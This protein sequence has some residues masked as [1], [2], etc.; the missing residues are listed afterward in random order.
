MIRRGVFLRVELK[1]LLLLFGVLCMGGSSDGAVLLTRVRKGFA[2]VEA[3]LREGDRVERISV[4]E[5]EIPATAFEWW[6]TIEE[7]A[8]REDV[9]LHV[10]RDGTTL[11]IKLNRDDW[12]VS[13]RPLMDSDANA[14]MKDLASSILSRTVDP[15]VVEGVF[16]RLMTSGDFGTAIWLIFETRVSLAGDEGGREVLDRILTTLERRV[17]ESPDPRIGLGVEYVRAVVYDETGRFDEA[18]LALKKF[19]E[20]SASRPGVQLLP[21]RALAVRAMALVNSG[22]KEDGLRHFGMAREAVEKIAPDSM[23]LAN[24]LHEEGNLALTLGKL[25]VARSAIEQ[26]S[27][28][29]LRRAPGSVVWADSL[30]LQGLLA[31]KSGDSMRAEELLQEK[32]EFQKSHDVMPEVI[33]NTYQNLGVVAAGLR[34]LD[35]A[36]LY[37]QEALKISKKIDPG[38][39]DEALVLGNSAIIAQ[40]R[41]DL[42]RSEDL[43][44][45]ALQILEKKGEGD[46]DLVPDLINLGK[47]SAERG[48]LDSAE[49]YYLRGLEIAEEQA[50]ESDMLAVLIGNLGWLKKRQGNIPEAIE[51]TRRSLELIA[52][53]GGDALHAAELE[54]NL[55]RLF[56]ESDQVSEAGAVLKSSL[57]TRRRVAPSSI[58]EAKS[59]DALGLLAEA[60]GNLEK[61]AEYLEQA[62]EISR[63][64]APGTWT[65]AEIIHDLA[66]AYD[67]MARNNAAVASGFETLEA[68]EKQVSRLGANEAVRANFRSKYIPY[69]RDLE[70]WLIEIGDDA[71]AFEVFERS[72]ARSFAALVA[73]RDMVPLSEIDAAL[74]LR[75]KELGDRYDEILGRMARADPETR[76][77]LLDQLRLLLERMNDLREDVR[78]RSPFLARMRYPESLGAGEA[79][80]LLKGGS[81]ALVYS[82]GRQET[83]LYILRPGEDVVSRRIALSRREL[84]DKVGVFR[85]LVTKMPSDHDA[86]ELVR[87]VGSRLFEVLVAPAADALDP[88]TR[89][90]IVPDGP[91]QALPFAA[92]VDEDGRYLVED[93]AVSKVLS[94][95]VLAEIRSLPE[96]GVS[97]RRL[98][99]FGDPWLSEH[100]RRDLEE[101]FAGVKRDESFVPLP[102]AREEVEKI[103]GL[104]PERS[105]IFIGRE[106]T[107]SNFFKEAP[108]ASNLHLATH[109]VVDSRLP[110]NSAIILASL[111]GE[112]K[113]NGLAQA[114]EIIENLRL[115]TGVVCLSGCESGLGSDLDG[116]GLIGL[117]RAFELAGAHSIVHMLWPVEDEAQAELMF[118]TYSALYDGLPVDEALRQAQLGFIR[119]EVDLPGRPESVIER[120]LAFFHLFFGNRA[121]LD[122]PFFWAGAMIEGDAS[123][124]SGELVSR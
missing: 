60:E 39:R 43:L 76:A 87:H 98:I 65:Q 22:K 1:L 102:G 104:E 81:V 78:R 83:I 49:T 105:E 120:F 85:G 95:S 51:L 63:S 37:F 64:S 99:A 48:N 121:Y 119:K 29:T 6:W 113:K 45:Q 66:V 62:V 54:E 58:D 106:A 97:G 13:I 25:D 26:E 41:G 52:S 122:H 55:G 115:K 15:S 16:S 107:E 53:S 110:L 71:R 80:G 94:L 68:L 18:F 117:T 101:V 77:E 84:E 4:G 91:L 8:P 5:E 9:T 50:P 103:T 24:L 21:C 30:S 12:G 40:Y 75:R 73:Q 100:S 27:R 67:V 92:L 114:W 70:G 35:R 10:T 14:L 124:R 20:D 90:I 89:V 111:T 19:T 93:H 17:G 96:P 42:V 61:A 46:L 31:F 7:K 32:L 2:G 118:R 86:T 59:L 123:I 69:Y 11:H 38:G 33:S 3:G 34:R 72:R 88:G 74:D 116:E 47:L 56:L 57:E 44:K 28:L 82:V 36:D 112:E 23:L 108:K 79:A 109:V